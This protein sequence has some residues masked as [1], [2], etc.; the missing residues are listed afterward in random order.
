VFD[1]AAVAQGDTVNNFDRGLDQLVLDV[2][3]SSTTNL[4]VVGSTSATT[5]GVESVISSAVSS[6]TTGTGTLDVLLVSITDQPSGFGSNVKQL[7]IVDADN[8]GDYNAN[9]DYNFY[10]SNYGGMIGANDVSFGFDAAITF[11]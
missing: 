9:S 4:S 5:A 7:V 1:S 2:D 6:W 8:S 3:M 11:M 10:V